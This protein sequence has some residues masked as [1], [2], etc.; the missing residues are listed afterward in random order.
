MANEEEQGTE[1][2][3][4]DSEDMQENDI[5]SYETIVGNIVGLNKVNISHV[6]I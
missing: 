1:E 6:Q 2:E 5:N 4:E 3:S